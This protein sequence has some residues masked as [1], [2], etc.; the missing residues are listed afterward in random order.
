MNT[1]FLVGNLATDVTTRKVV[2]VSGD[3]RRETSTASFLLAVNR[4]RRNGENAGADF[5][6]VEVWGRMADVASQYLARGRRIAVVGR[7]RSNRYQAQDGT[8][9]YDLRVVARQLQFLGPRKDIN[10]AA[11]GAQAED[12]AEPDIA[13]EDLPF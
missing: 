11:S 7:L 10:G 1:V 13:A 12:P 4:P 2:V 6:R 9:R 8:T 5:V 3:D